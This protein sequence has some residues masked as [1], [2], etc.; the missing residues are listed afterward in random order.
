MSYNE[1][2]LFVIGFS[3]PSSIGDNETG[4]DKPSG[5]L[6]NTSI[7]CSHSFRLKKLFSYYSGLLHNILTFRDP[8]VLYG[9]GNCDCNHMNKYNSHV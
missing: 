9:M 5:M 2:D 6:V 1:N 7:F 4:G 8:S 3:K